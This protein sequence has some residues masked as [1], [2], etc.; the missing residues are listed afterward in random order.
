[1][2]PDNIA[3]L[4]FNDASDP[5]DWETIDPRVQRDELK[6][7]LLANL[8]PFLQWVFPNGVVKGPKFYVGNVRGDPGRSLEIELTGEKAGVFIDRATGDSGDVFDILAHHEGYDA[9]REFRKVLAAAARWLGS[10][11]LALYSKTPPRKVN[12]KAVL[13]D[14]GMYTAKWDYFSAEGKL[15]ACVYRY[16]PPSGKQYRPRDVVRGVVGA[17]NPRPLYNLPGLATADTVVLVE[18]EK[19]AQALIDIGICATTAMNGA[20][21]PA[22]KT[23]WTPLKDKQILVWPDKDK[24]GW[25]YATAAGNA[26]LSA[27][28]VSC[29]VLLPPEDKPTSWD[30]ADAIAEGF[31]CP[32]FIAAAERITLQPS[33][34]LE[35]PGPAERTVDGSEDALA[36]DFTRRYAEDW[37][38]VALWGQ[39]LVWTGSRWHPE[40]TL[41]ATHLIRQVCRAASLNAASPRTAAKIASSG[42]AS[43]AE[44]FARTDRRHAATVEEWDADPWLLNTPGGVVDL[45]TGRM[46]PHCREDRTTKITTAT[47]R[48]DCPTWKAFLNDVTRGDVELIAYLQRMAGYCLTGITT[49]HA[50]FFLY[51]TGA[52]GKSVFV[53][54]VS[55]ILGDYA[56]NAPMDTFME[57][58]SDRHPTDLAGLRGARLVSLIETEQGRRWAESK[59]K[60]LTGGDKIAARFMRQDFFEYV[61]KFKL[62]IA[63]NHK[64]TIRSI[65]EA[66]RRRLHLIPF[67][68]TISPE[69]RD[70]RL[71]EKLLKERD[72]ILAW[73]VQGCLDWQRQ[74]L[75]PPRC[76]QEA[77]EEYFEEEDAVGE[78]IEEECFQ[79]TGARVAIAEIYQRWRERAEKRGE[80]VG[81]IRWFVQQLVGRGYQRVRTHGGGKAIAGLSLRPREPLHCPIGMT[82]GARPK[83]RPGDRR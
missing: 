38:Y 54:T 71:P 20:Q 12:G 11:W 50:L 9:K 4:D 30:A 69:K 42:T 46:R 80:F 59:I 6:A 34:P 13:D 41:C 5:F 73:A 35:T 47:P 7:R 51:G 15:I 44:R 77:T 23:D 21:A 66:M 3:W 32:A 68:V 19:C 64:P 25:E 81:T 57:T 62:V 58:R 67:T 29:T 52:N 74:R 36:L 8:T 40:H 31:D 26:A 75:N 65:D 27:G 55:A 16:D 48:G 39:W 78:F 33:P 61:P 70:Q 45:H 14:L 17:P 37:R 18:G 28:A 82:D 72:G 56:T 2:T 24:P 53:N 49:E 1:M 83:N 43:G 22:E 76:V 10:D 63:G 60:A 79:S